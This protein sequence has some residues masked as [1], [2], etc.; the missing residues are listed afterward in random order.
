MTRGQM[1]ARMLL[2]PTMVR[3]GRTLT[4]LLAVTVAAAVATAT[5]TLYTDVQAKLHKEFRRYGANVVVSAKEGQPLP[6]DA[7]QRVD[8]VLAGRGIA[9]PFSYAVAKTDDG[10][11]LV[12]AGVDFTRVRRLNDWWSVS[13]WPTKASQALVGTRAAQ[14]LAQSGGG[15]NLHFN[16]KQI[17]LAKSGTLRTGSGEDSRVYL[18]LGEFAAWTGLS[19]STIEIAV[20]G[21]ASD[22]SQTISTLASALP[23]ARV[24]PVRQI[25]EAEGRVLSKTRLALLASSL[26]IVLTAALCLLATLTASV[27]DRRKDFAVMKALG[28]SNRAV[29]A[30]FAAEAI[31]LGGLGAIAGFA[32]G[33]GI[34]FLIGKLNFSAVVSPRFG[35]FPSVLLGSILISLGAALL[36]LRLLQRVQPATILRGE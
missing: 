11:P 17:T 29:N 9:A 34:A 14:V 25:V 13:A 30:V 8:S 18:Q 36:P 19:T 16:N 1:F 20:A 7:L 22:I 3:R 21:S 15:F 5:L 28:A 4:G 27:L 23:T 6:A 24:E 33:M 26:L 32:A 2:R 31:A 35:I 12:A 10:T